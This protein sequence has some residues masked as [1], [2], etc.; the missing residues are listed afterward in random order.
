MKTRR[1]LLVMLGVVIGL[2]GCGDEKKESDNAGADADVFEEAVEDVVEA[3]ELDYMPSE[4]PEDVL[5]GVDPGSEGMGGEAFDEI[6]GARDE[7]SYPGDTDGHVETGAEGFDTGETLK[8]CTLG[9]DE[10]AEDENCAPSDDGYSLVCRKAG[11]VQPGGRCLAHEDCSKGS[12][13]ITYWQDIAYC[14]PLCSQS[15]SCPEEFQI[16]L[17]WFG[18]EGTLAGVCFGTNC[19]PPD[20]G[21]AE[22]DRCTVLGNQVFDCVPAGP[23]PVGGDCSE[24]DCV[25]GAVCVQSSGESICRAFC[26]KAED[27]TGADDHCIFPWRFTDFG[28]CK[29]GCDPILQE[30]CNPGEGCYF[31]D[32]TIGTTLCWQ[33][34]T[35][36][37]GE[38]CSSFIEFCKPGLDCILQPDTNP[39]EYYCRAYCDPAHPCPQGY[40]CSYPIASPVMGVCLP[41]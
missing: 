14:K 31:S 18:N 19:T 13:C 24:E 7:I 40:K 8:S 1:W 9:G 10:C 37:E 5:Q 30:G 29:E 3:R 35:L 41:E 34:G 11:S 2:V 33:A 23:V 26:G 4:E 39:Y 27:C 36:E 21:C 22:G 6:A 15:V 17:P 32:P 28:Y 25:A 38:D 20:I 12:A 16:C